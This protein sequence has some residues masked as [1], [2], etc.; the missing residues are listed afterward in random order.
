MAPPILPSGAFAT[1]AEARAIEARIAELQDQID[2]LNT[3]ALADIGRLQHKV[4]AALEFADR[5]ADIEA[6]VAKVEAGAEPIRERLRSIP[7]PKEIERRAVEASIKAAEDTGSHILADVK[8]GVEERLTKR[9][10]E[11]MRARAARAESEA[12]SLRRSSQQRDEK[13][14]DRAAAATTSKV[15]FRRE[16]AMAILAAVLAVLAGWLSLRPPP[17]KAVEPLVLPPTS[18]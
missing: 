11:S 6:R 1:R 16:I 7:D 5:L 15:A 9:D 3:K 17:Q 10:M 8:R 12:E 2:A 14:D 4:D 18:H 13:K